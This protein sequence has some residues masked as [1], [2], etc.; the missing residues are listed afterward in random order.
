MRYNA[1]NRGSV[2]T[3]KYVEKQ[4]GGWL[5]RDTRVSLDSIIYQFRSGRSPEAIQ[6]AFPVLS[7]SQIYGAIAFYLDHQ[8]EM[9]E[10]LAHDEATEEKFREEIARLYPK[11]AAIKERIKLRLSENPVSDRQR[12]ARRHPS[13]D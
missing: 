11:G 9:D 2:M 13:I 12:S 8:K 7:L 1:V 4:G 10:Y 6:D 5:I 3:E